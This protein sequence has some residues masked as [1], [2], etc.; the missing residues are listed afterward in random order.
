MLLSRYTRRRKFITLLDGAAAAWPLA[1]LA[2]QGGVS[3]TRSARSR[4]TG[5]YWVPHWYKPSHWLAYWDV[6]NRP[7][8]NPRYARG[9]PETWWYDRDK[10]ANI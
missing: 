5:R 8:T 3:P 9:V 6:F 10:A 4:R 1:A 2:Q 7:A